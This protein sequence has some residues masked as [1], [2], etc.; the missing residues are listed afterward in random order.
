MGSFRYSGAKLKEK[1]VLH[2]IDG[3]SDGK[4]KLVKI[5]ISSDEVGVFNFRVCHRHL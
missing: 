4:L 5:E 1:G 2:S 3:L